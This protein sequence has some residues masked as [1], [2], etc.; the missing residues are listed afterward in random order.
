MMSVIAGTMGNLICVMTHCW[1]RGEEIILGDKSHIHIYEQGG[2]A[3]VKKQCTA[4]ATYDHT[5]LCKTTPEMVIAVNMEIHTITSNKKDRIT[6]THMNICWVDY[7]QSYTTLTGSCL[8]WCLFS[9][10]HSTAEFTTEQWRICQ[11]AHLTWTRWLTRFDDPPM[12]ITSRGQ[13]WSA[14][15]TRT[16]SVGGNLCHWHG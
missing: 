2:I 3:Q 15:K 14:L 1:G 7:F 13:R 8:W 16:T 11:M 4:V 5:A 12:T 9:P 10:L 6:H